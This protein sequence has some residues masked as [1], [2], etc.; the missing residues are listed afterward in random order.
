MAKYYQNKPDKWKGTIW[1]D[2]SKPQIITGNF[3]PAPENRAIL[4][5]KTIGGV[6]KTNR[7]I[8]TNQELERIGFFQCERATNQR[9][10][11]RAKRN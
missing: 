3:R 7:V 10:E 6:H 5:M 1:E 8:K 2:K 11:R 9:N 4:E